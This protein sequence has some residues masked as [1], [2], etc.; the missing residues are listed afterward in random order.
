V[1]AFLQG[2]Y[3]EPLDPEVEAERVVGES[4]RLLSRRLAE[5]EEVPAGLA[6]PEVGAA[7]AIE[8]LVRAVRADRIPPPRSTRG[9][10]AGARADAAT[11]ELLGWLDVPLDDA[12]AVVVTGFNEGRVPRSIGGHPFLPDSTRRRLGLADDDDRLAR[13]VYASTVLLSTGREVCFVTGRRSAEGDPLVPSRLAFHRP[14]EEIP[15]RVRHF[16]PAEEEL[17]SAEEVEEGAE[18]FA[19]PRVERFD[20][21]EVMSVS[22]FRTYLGSPY[23]FFVERVLKLRTVDDRARELDPLRFGSL[24]HDVLEAFGKEGPRDSES[25]DEIA[26]FLRVRVDALVARRYGASPLPAVGLQAEQLKYRLGIFAR[27]QA[28]R[29]RAGW[30][31]VEVEWERDPLARLDVDGEAMA[32]RGRIDR[33]D[34][35]DDGRWAVIDYK[36]G[37]KT[38]DP[39]DAHRSRGAWL[40]LQLP[41]Y[42]LLTDGMY[43]GE[44]ELGYCTL[45]TDEATID[46]RWASWTRADLDDALGA[47]RDVVRAVRDGAFWE[48]GRT[49]NEEILKALWGEGM[50]VTSEAEEA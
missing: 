42:R 20:I 48:P 8:L 32:I 5:L 21:P 34:A 45:G 36:T 14:E 46:F 19:R 24:A 37:E 30:R 6:G 40:D 22:S 38:G 50:I 10:R 26:D 28:E 12:P 47:A 18:R 29:R 17:R 13:D 2:V 35:H 27:R 3:R 31:I 43:P 23:R 44:P 39:E 15:A 33:I 4:L 11:V 9:T 49:P 41:L 25:P 16:L 7:E 1:R